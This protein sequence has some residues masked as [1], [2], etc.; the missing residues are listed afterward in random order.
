MKTYS[1]EFTHEDYRRIEEF[2]HWFVRGN[3]GVWRPSVED[4]LGMVLSDG[5]IVDHQHLPV[6][7]EFL[8]Q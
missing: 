7:E 6:I 8:N 2:T 4:A 3:G 5:T 1:Q